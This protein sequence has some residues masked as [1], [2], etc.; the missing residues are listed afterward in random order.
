[1]RTG[2]FGGAFDPF[3]N[4]H[5]S[6]VECAKNELN[7]DKVVVYPSFA[8]PHKNC[9]A[10]YEARREL[11]E[12]ALKQC[13]YVVIDDVEKERDADKNPTCEVLP[14]LKKKYAAEENYFII[15]GD[16]MFNFSKWIKPEIV[17][18]TMKI[19][20]VARENVEEV[21][22]KA[23]EAR[24]NYGADVTVLNYVGKAVSGSLVK[25]K[26]EFGEKPDEIDEKVY[27]KI[28]EK[29]L[30]RE[31]K[32]VVEKLKNN[33][34]E[35]TFEH[36]KR[37]VYYAFKLNVKLGLPYEKV[38]LAAGLHDCAKHLHRAMDGVPPAVEHQFLGA[39]VAENEYGVKDED[40][41]NAIKY[42]T[43]GKPD[44]TTLEKLVFCADMLEE[45]R[46]YPGVTELRK[47]I[48][49]DFEKGFVECVNS[50]MKKLIEDG[51][52]FHF[53]TKECAMYY[54]H[55]REEKINDGDTNESATT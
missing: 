4:E 8:P 41:L 32:D 26:I 23:E 25:A 11:A 33:I 20:V 39:E 29:G 30:Y 36:V 52:P 13:G 9:T 14:L 3:H 45:G 7:L 15:G 42:H 28:I 17:A 5:K 55:R 31:H 53:L 35:R 10:P 54:N 16:S 2:F 22:R 24:K 34:P 21:E 47:T 48:E 19:A 44:M 27:E 49:N 1:M 40:V 37:T 6:I 50:S 38:F 43:T 12:T 46:S 18:K 51:K